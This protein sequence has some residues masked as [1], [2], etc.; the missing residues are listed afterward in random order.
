MSNLL[1]PTTTGTIVGPDGQHALRP[2]SIL[3]SGE[4]ALIRTYLSFLMRAGYEPELVCGQCYDGRRESKA[5]FNISDSQIV[6]VCG[7]RMLF[8]E[9]VTPPEQMDVPRLPK[10]PSETAATKTTPL[11]LDAVVLLRA[12]KSAILL[13]YHLKEILRCNYCDA[14]DLHDGCRASVTGRRVQ[15]ECR[16]RTLAWTDV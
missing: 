9:G 5:Q 16:C 15:I 1:T 11:T 14:L 3:S 13:K 2:T 6:I 8:Y 10:A 7:C 12:Y 4:A